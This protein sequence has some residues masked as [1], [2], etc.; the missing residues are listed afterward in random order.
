[1]LRL[2]MQEAKP[3]VSQRGAQTL[4]RNDRDPQIS[5][6]VITI[7]TWVIDMQIKWLYHKVM[8]WLLIHDNF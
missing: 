8:G 5:K 6:S 7:R 1:M 3:K 2:R 4:Y